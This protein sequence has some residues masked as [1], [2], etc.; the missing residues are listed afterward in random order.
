M[1][2]ANLHLL[3]T[4][5]QVRP[6]LSRSRPKRRMS[7]TGS[8]PPFR[9]LSL[10]QKILFNRSSKRITP[11]SRT[12]KSL[13][14]SGKK[15]RWNSKWK[16][17]VGRGVQRPLDSGMLAMHGHNELPHRLLKMGNGLREALRGKMFPAASAGIKRPTQEQKLLDRPLTRL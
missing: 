6:N 17:I 7:A 13:C 1:L 11:Y 4:D 15:T 3:S 10:P 2:A 12:V 14:W 16:N 9:R 8:R 5:I